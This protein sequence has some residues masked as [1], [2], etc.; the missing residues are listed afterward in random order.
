MRGLKFSRSTDEGP[1]AGARRE[2]QSE[3][4]AAYFPGSSLTPAPLPVMM[5]RRGMSSSPRFRTRSRGRTHEKT[6]SRS[7]FSG[8][9][10][11]SVRA[12]STAYAATMTA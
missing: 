1:K 4:F 2:V 12:A 6:S 7:T 3:R 10:G 5:R 8:R 9:R 11:P